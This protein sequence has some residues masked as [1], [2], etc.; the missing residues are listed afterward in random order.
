MR[1]LGRGTI[2][3]VNGASAFKPRGSVAGTSIAFAGESA[4]AQLLHDEL[5][6][7]GIHAAQLIIPLGIGGGDPSH[8]PVALAETL[9]HIH[10]K[11]EGFRTF[12]TPLD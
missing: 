5:A 12:V 11:R 9:W 4:Y 7:E 10:T 3:F 6:P 8:E 2:L 1:A